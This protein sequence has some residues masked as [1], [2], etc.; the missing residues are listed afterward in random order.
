MNTTI[1]DVARLAGV[2][3]ATVSRVVNHAESG[4]GEEVRERVLKTIQ[5]TG[6]KSNLIAKSMITNRTNTI[7]VL[8]PDIVNPFYHDVLR[9]INEYAQEHQ[10][11]VFLYNTNGGMEQQEASIDM[12]LAR[13]VD[14]AIL[15]GYFENMTTMLT[16]KLKDIP[17]VIWD[18]IPKMGDVAQVHTNDAE[19]SYE[20]VRYL[21]EMGHRKIG[22][23]IGPM[24]YDITKQRLKG[25]KKALKEYGIDY[26][27][28][29]IKAGLFT[30]KSAEEPAKELLADS[31]VTAIYCFNDLMAYGVYLMCAKL[32]KK[33]PDDISVVGYDGIVYSEYLTPP[34][35]TI[36][37]PS[38]DI[39][40]Q[41]VK[42]LLDLIEKRPLK[43]KEV[44]L[45]NELVLRGSVR[46]L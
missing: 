40:L 11:S 44:L 23:I 45:E 26:D 43:K 21:L 15:V 32:G 30:E 6:Y 8:S 41:A 12:L 22:C 34:L 13:G 14:G 20:L 31:S 27:R 7:A 33:I 35:T 36:R 29:L 16:N 2:S 1:K 3:I 28:S 38:Y 46:K 42:I 9:G 5:E 37:Q 39:G 25:Y 10:Y 19:S 24:E 18:R 17:V 4:V